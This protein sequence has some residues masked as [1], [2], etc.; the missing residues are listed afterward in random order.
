MTRI[1]MKAGLA[2]ALAAS[3]MIATPAVAGNAEENSVPVRYSDLNLATQ[4][5]QRALERRLNRAAEKVCGI[6]RRTSGMALPSSEARS[7]YRKTIEGFEREIASR[8]EQ[9]QQQ[10]RG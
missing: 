4:D 1:S 5:G 7:C 8:V 6:D 2:A 9:Q 3:A 10:Q